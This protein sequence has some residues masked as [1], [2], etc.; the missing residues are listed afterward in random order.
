[1]TDLIYLVTQLG[2]YL[3]TGVT[4]KAVP[5]FH[6]RMQLSILCKG[7]LVCP[8]LRGFRIFQ[9]AANLQLAPILRCGKSAVAAA[10]SL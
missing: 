6:R 10:R 4:L 5:F 9:G 8:L 7:P 1:M 2:R 3:S